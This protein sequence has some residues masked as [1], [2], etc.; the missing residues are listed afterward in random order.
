MWIG[1]AS[2]FDIFLHTFLGLSVE[3]FSFELSD[4]TVEDRRRKLIKTMTLYM[5]IILNVPCLA[6]DPFADNNHQ[7]I[8]AHEF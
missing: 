1:G 5:T 7:S 3:T 2:S 6:E 8:H 4:L